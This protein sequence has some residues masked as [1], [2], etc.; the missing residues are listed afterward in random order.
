MNTKQ[1]STNL[2]EFLEYMR[3]DYMEVCMMDYCVNHED[4]PYTYD[5][6]VDIELELKSVV[7]SQKE[8]GCSNGVVVED[9]NELRYTV[10][11]INGLNN[12]WAI[13]TIPNLRYLNW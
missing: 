11:H 6:L 2:V 9:T 4:F 1:L 7:D 12:I 8:G 10:D 3:S 13:T 5:E